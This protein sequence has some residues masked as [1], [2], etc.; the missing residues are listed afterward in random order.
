MQNRPNKKFKTRIFRVFIFIAFVP[1]LLISYN[2]LSIIT[3]TRK[4]NI[5]ELQALA[6]ETAGEKIKKFLDQK[7]ETFNLVVS[8]AATDLAEIDAANLNHLIDS[9]QAAAG[10]VL[11]INFIDKN[12]N[13]IIKRVAAENLPKSNISQQPEFKATVAGKNYFGPVVYTENGPVMQMAAPVENKDKEI[14]GAIS[15]IINLNSLQTVI[16]KIKLGNTGFVYLADSD[17]YL[18]AAGNTKFGSAGD[19]IK[20]IALAA[21]VIAGNFRDGLAAGDRYVNSLGEEVIF[22]GRPMGKINWFVMSEWPKK[23]AFS[24]IDSLIKQAVLTIAVSLI[25]VIILSFFITERVVKPIEAL[26]HGAEEIAKGNLNYRLDLKTGDEFETLGERFNIMIKAL[27]ENQKLRDEFVFIA[28]HELRTPVTAI[29]GYLSMIMDGSFGQVPDKIESNLKIVNGANERLVQLV[30]DLLEV[31]RSESNAI[32]I[33]LTPLSIT[34]SVKTA[35]NELKAAAGKKG[36]KIIYEKTAEDKKIKAD[37][38]KLKEVLANLINNAIKY[39]PAA[40]AD[41][42]AGEKEKTIKIKHEIDGDYLITRIK[43]SGLGMAPEN[44][45]K[46][47]SKFYRVKT[48]ATANIEGTGLGLFICKQIIEKMG[49]EIWAKSKAGQG[50]TFSFKLLLA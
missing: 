45:E 4:Q 49:G 42:P 20:P 46:L 40:E 6:L 18:I 7:I 28:A 21:N 8:G 30:Q 38:Y 14:I 47:F 23:D 43:D 25:L 17:G 22:A 10:D 5:A 44:M 36:I 35:I 48:D 15:A 34:E 3:K 19:N 37:S 39:T 41:K 16:K 50:S 12:G 32:K 33:A 2:S 29:K 27:K 31:A 26:N 9:I 1:F 24:A 13:E 11:E